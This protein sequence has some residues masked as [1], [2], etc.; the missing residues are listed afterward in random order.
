M[1]LFAQLDEDVCTDLAAYALPLNPSASLAV[2]AAVAP[3]FAQVCSPTHARL[4][5]L[6][7]HN[8]QNHSL[9]V[10]AVRIAVPSPGAHHPPHAASPRV[11]L[12]RTSC[13]LAHQSSSGTGW[14]RRCCGRSL[15]CVAPAAARVVVAAFT[16]SVRC[17]V[18][19]SDSLHAAACT[20]VPH[21]DIM[22]CF[23]ADRRQFPQVPCDPC[24]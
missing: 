3:R 6:T 24:I 20:L 16:T 14:V 23:S 12:H 2:H 4:L 15:G 7:P 5:P 11:I 18:G 10:A 21:R 22:R 9:I 1:V 13:V 17:G 19:R 8:Q